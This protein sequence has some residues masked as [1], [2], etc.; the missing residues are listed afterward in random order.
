[1]NYI[2]LYTNKY[3]EIRRH[4]QEK[5]TSAS[6][7]EA[8]QTYTH[9]NRDIMADPDCDFCGDLGCVYCDSDGDNDYNLA[10]Y[11]NDSDDE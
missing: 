2:S 11:N 7:A 3:G 6:E 4:T 5:Q 1:M 10:Q 9:T 8:N